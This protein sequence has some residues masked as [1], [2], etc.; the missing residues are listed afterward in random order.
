MKNA[1]GLSRTETRKQSGGKR[2]VGRTRA[3]RDALAAASGFGL[4]SLQARAEQLGARTIGDLPS[5]VLTSTVDGKCSADPVWRGELRSGT[6][7]GDG[8]AR[9]ATPRAVRAAG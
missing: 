9:N 7:V 2:H 4:Q 5:F 8:A 6:V 3:E 1:E